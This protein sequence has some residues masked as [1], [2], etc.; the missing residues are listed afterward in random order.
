MESNEEKPLAGSKKR[1]MTFDEAVREA[2]ASEDDVAS[3]GEEGEAP[4]KPRPAAVARVDGD[5]PDWVVFPDDFRL[6][7]GEQVAFIRFRKEWCKGSA[8]H[9]GDRGCIV[10]PITS[11]EEKLAAKRARGVQELVLSELTKQSIR[12]VMDNVGT[13]DAVA[14]AADWSGVVPAGNIDR[15]FDEVGPKCRPLVI[16]VYARLHTLTQEEGLRFFAECLCIRS[17]VAG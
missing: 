6:P 2:E 5:V 11:A 8:A 15:F 3:L 4:P 12:A 9:K 10:Y 13:P 14:T 7:K 17:A 16:N 1:R